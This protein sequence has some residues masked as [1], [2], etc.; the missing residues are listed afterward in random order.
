MQMYA[1][2]PTK[3]TLLAAAVAGLLAVAVDAGAQAR[4]A[5]RIA[6]LT[7]DSPCESPKNV[8]YVAFVKGLDALGY[9]NDAN[10][11]IECRSAEGRYE[12]LDAL[13]ADL[14]RRDPALIVA[15]AGPASLAAKRATSAIPIVSVYTAD[16]VGLGLAASLA[17]PG[18]NVTG[19]SSLSSDY[20]AKSLQLLKEVVPRTSR[21]GVLGHVANPTFAI[22]RRELESAARALHMTLDFGPVDSLASVEPALSAMRGRGAE[23]FLVMHQP[24][25]FENRE[26]I[27]SA[28]ARLRLPA[29]YGSQ[30]AVESGGLMSYAVN[31]SD[32]FRRAAS[33]V[34]KVL[35]GVKPAELP[36]EQPTSFELAINLGTA[37]SLGLTIPQALLL[38]AE[39]VFQ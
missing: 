18:G 29:I 10:V 25:T 13:A 19:L 8:G 9:R 33:F 12:R 6:Y 37:R 39:R 11:A 16:P 36:I 17:K 4:T 26:H 1:C 27:V 20:V 2:M 23:A 5:Q 34:V 38:R 7:S 28:A 35:Q 22:Y 32:M 30:E 31:V 21:V 14:V 3:R 15:A 24:F